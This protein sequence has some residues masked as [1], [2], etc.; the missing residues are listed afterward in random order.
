MN[1]HA[2]VGWHGRERGLPNDDQSSF[3]EDTARA[4]MDDEQRV[5]EGGRG[6]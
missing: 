4:E 1:G 5:A 6:D 3:G 2:F